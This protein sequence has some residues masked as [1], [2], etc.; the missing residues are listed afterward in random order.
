M[1]PA[2][3]TEYEIRAWLRSVG[4]TRV[5]LPRN[6]DRCLYVEQPGGGLWRVQP[7]ITGAFTVEPYPSG[8][9]NDGRPGGGGS[10]A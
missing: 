1:A 10:D 8:E 4:L 6:L 5:R 2:I 3:M 7:L 9:Y